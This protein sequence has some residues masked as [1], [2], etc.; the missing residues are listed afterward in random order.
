MFV[1]VYCN[2]Q[3]TIDSS[4]TTFII[5]EK[6][7]GVDR[8][9][10]IYRKFIPGLGVRHIAI[11]RPSVEAFGEESELLTLQFSNEAKN[12][13]KLLDIAVSKREFNFSRLSINILVYKELVADLINIYSNSPAWA[14]YQQKNSGKLRQ[15]ITLWEG[16]QIT[17]PSFDVNVAAAVLNKSAFASVIGDLFKEYGYT[18]SPP[19]FPEEHQQIVSTDNLMLAGKD[20]NLYIPVPDYYFTLTKINK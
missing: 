5:H 12:L 2:G 14:D 15:T 11:Y 13:K 10:S 16:S 17:E 18:A 8:T 20:P 9:L 7:K 19:A 6:S 4:R 3:L 1:T